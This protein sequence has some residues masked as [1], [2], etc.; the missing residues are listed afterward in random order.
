MKGFSD[1]GITVITQ[2]SKKKTDSQQTHIKVFHYHYMNVYFDV[3]NDVLNILAN[4]VNAN[5][6]F[7]CTMTIFM[8][9]IYAYSLGIAYRISSYTNYS[10]D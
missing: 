1:L 2:A 10:V 9:I 4:K 7:K 3:I 5:K 6:L 8:S